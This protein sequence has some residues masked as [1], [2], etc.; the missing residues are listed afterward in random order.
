MICK[1]WQSWA[2][3]LSIMFCSKWASPAPHTPWSGPCLNAYPK[4]FCFYCPSHH[5]LT[6]CTVLSAELHLV[7]HIWNT[8]A[9]HP[10]HTNVCYPEVVEITCFLV[11]HVLLPLS[12]QLGGSFQ[13]LFHPGHKTAELV[14]R[15]GTVPLGSSY[16]TQAGPR[17]RA[18]W[19]LFQHLTLSSPDLWL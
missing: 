4:V 3:F 15:G 12:A 14:L 7:W 13:D 2:W 1:T 17:G 9:S 6:A 18:C 11:L 16:P 19:C 10:T 5:W 8:L